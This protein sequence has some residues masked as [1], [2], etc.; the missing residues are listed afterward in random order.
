MNGKIVVVGSMNT[1]ITISME[2][3]PGRGETVLGGDYHKS[4]G[5]KGANQA[6]AAA[7][8]GADVVFIAKAGDDEF[9]KEAINGY[10]SCGVNTE[11]ILT[12]KNEKTGLAL[13]WVDSKGENSIAVA[14]GA[15]K[16][17][18]PED[19]SSCEDVIKNAGIV[20]VQLE[21]PLETVIRA[22]DIAHE[23]N[24]PVILNPA[25]A[26]ELPESLLKKINI[27][28]PNLPELQKITGMKAGEDK[29]VE[30]ACRILKEK[31][32]QDVIVTLGKK[33]SC[34]LTGKE[35]KYIG[36]FEVKAVDTTAAGDVFNGA[37]AAA[38][39]NNK[40]IKEAMVF[41]SAA[42]AISVTKMGAQVSAPSGEE[43]NTFLGERLLSFTN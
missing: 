13:I 31:G 28:T 21:I 15:N 19:I 16:K 40:P 43:I 22:V 3:F 9:G 38:L 6:V 34:I 26:I 30:T 32:V 10:R 41:A 5:G 42:A 36:A 7:K 14:S 2:K 24:V 33:G 20:V 29:E 39:V 23:N 12:G 4:Q 27:I 17:L 35:F 11:H 25:P 37:L 1:D 8:A 18:T